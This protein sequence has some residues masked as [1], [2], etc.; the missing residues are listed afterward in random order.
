MF[1]KVFVANRG[2]IAC[3]VIRACRTMGI[4]SVI[5]FHAVDQST[6]GVRLADFAVELTAPVDQSPRAAY[7]D[8]AQ[9]VDAAKR[10][11]CEAVH[12]GYGFL[13]ERA[14]FAKACAEAG[15]TFVGPSPEC[16]ARLGDK[17]QAREA[18]RS[19]GLPLVPG[20][21]GPC[22]ELETALELAEEMGYPV[23][24]KAAGGGGGRGMRRAYSKEELKVGFDQARR[25]ALA[26]FGNDS[27]YLEKYIAK[28]RHIEIQ[29]LA[30]KH[31]NA[32]YLLERECS[33]QRRFQKMLEEAPS[34]FLDPESRKSMGEA[35]VRGALAVGYHNAGTFEFLVDENKNFYFLEVNTRL[36]VEHPVTEEITGVD[37]VCEQFKVAYGEKL[38]LKQEDIKQRGWSIECRITCEDPDANFRPSVGTV[39]GLRLPAGPGVRVDTHLYQGYSVPND[40]DSMLAKLIV[41]GSDR[42][43]AI[44]RTLAALDEFEVAGFSTSI[45]FHKWLLSHPRFQAG[46]LS[47]HFLEEE[48]SGLPGDDVEISDLLTVAAVIQHKRSGNGGGS[49]PATTSRGNWAQ[50]SRLSGVGRF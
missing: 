44:Q 47:T 10:T 4:E 31:G 7:L 29:I 6:L 49:E 42:E 1:K 39:D 26:S 41:T 16:I 3:R 40:F 32:V 50:S 35:A 48:F 28:P 25:E 38:A 14:D 9:I 43:T 12:P 19:A 30:D 2:E 13:S 45:P 5:G 21:D 46:H 33:V 34:P 22:I 23:L 11:G 15:L 8:V 18:M 36:Q 37:L 17:N 24:I 20:S 27:V